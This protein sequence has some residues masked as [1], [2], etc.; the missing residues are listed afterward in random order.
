MGII[1]Y[2][3]FEAENIGVEK[4]L[5]KTQKLPPATP[6]LRI[7]QIS[8]IHFSNINSV[9]LARKIVDKIKLLNPHIIVSTGDFID[10][11][12]KEK[13]GGRGSFPEY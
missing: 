4:V 7:V 8:D 10:R 1:V 3:G 12:L 11:G 9:R 13:G 5:L 6:N 2:G